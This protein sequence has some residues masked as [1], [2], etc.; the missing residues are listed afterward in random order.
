MSHLAS[1]LN[2]NTFFALFGLPALFDIDTKQLKTN[3]L[4]LQKKYHPDNFANQDPK[5]RLNAEQN[6]ALIN[7]AFDVLSRYDSRAVYLLQLADIDFNAEKSI[8]NEPFLKQMM[9][10]RMD[11]EDAS[12]DQDREAISQITSQVDTLL[13]SAAQAFNDCYQA[14]DWQ[15][16]QRLAQELTFLANLHKDCVN[17]CVADG[18]DDN[19]DDDLYV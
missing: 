19:N 4:Q 1:D 6:T 5:A 8:F 11:L 9:A 3:F 7:H 15:N 18:S 10:Y 13:S 12:F 14:Q 2:D 17:A 16:A